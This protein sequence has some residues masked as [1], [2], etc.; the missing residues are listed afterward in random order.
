MPPVPSGHLEYYRR[1][2]I[3]PVRYDTSDLQR[4]LDRRGALYRTLGITP[5]AIR[6]ARVLEVAPGTGQNSLYITRLDPES[7]TFVEPN[8]VAVRDIVA[9]YAEL[10]EVA[11]EIVVSRFEAYDSDDR[12]D[13]IVCENWLG[14]S[15]H[16]RK[17]LHKLGRYV[18]DKGLL[19]VTAVS[20]VGILPNLL[21]RALV[22]PLD[23]SGPILCSQNKHALQ[24]I[25]NRTS[26]PSRP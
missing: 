19:V 18:D 15:E 13:I 9:V 2:G 16:D 24:G 20:P 21:R 5:V 4:H 25:W 26:A 11:P 12:F 14:S 1:H 8:S 22:Q 17:M 7:Y 6:N 3:N 10:G 23:V